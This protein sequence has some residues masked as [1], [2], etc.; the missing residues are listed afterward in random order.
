[1]ILTRPRRPCS[2]YSPFKCLQQ[3]DG[4]C[5][6]ALGGHTALLSSCNLFKVSLAMFKI[7]SEAAQLFARWAKP[8]LP[9]QAAQTGKSSA[10]GQDGG[11]NL[12][13]G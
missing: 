13:G 6:A 1:M 5:D 7:A 8:C 9:F 4:C 3:N 11:A 2:K 12:D 10:G